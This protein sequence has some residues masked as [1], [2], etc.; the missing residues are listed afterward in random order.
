[1][2][3]C[4]ALS[5]AL[6]ELAAPPLHFTVTTILLSMLTEGNNR[7]VNKL[8]RS[9]TINCITNLLLISSESCVAQDANACFK[10]LFTCIA[11]IRL[12]RL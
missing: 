4:S 6:A 9:I 12:I 5:V 10:T 3:R 11:V 7:N 2:A 8:Y 1:M